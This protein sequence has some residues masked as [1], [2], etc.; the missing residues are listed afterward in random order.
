M[1]AIGG[2]NVEIFVVDSDSAVGVSGEDGDLDVGGQEAGCGGG[3]EGQNGDVLEDE[4]WLWGA[5]DDVDEEDDEEDEEDE[6]EDAAEYAA[7]ELPTLLLVFAVLERH[8]GLGVWGEENL[9]R[10]CGDVEISLWGLFV[11]GG[12]HMVAGVK[13]NTLIME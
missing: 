2:K 3:I 1:A 11:G 7:F 8:G 12:F 13:M 4:V 9:E 5:E 10:K 6:G